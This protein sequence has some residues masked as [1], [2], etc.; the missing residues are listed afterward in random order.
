MEI[1]LQME[2]V[3]HLAKVSAVMMMVSSHFDEVMCHLHAEQL[4]PHT[5]L[6]QL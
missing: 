1:Q 5:Y 6:D 2:G 4:F 3:T